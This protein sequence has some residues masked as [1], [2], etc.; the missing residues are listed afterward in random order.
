MKKYIP[1]KGDRVREADRGGIVGHVDQVRHTSRGLEAKVWPDGAMGG[2]WIKA[3][4]LT[5]EGH[6]E[7]PPRGLALRILAGGA[8]GT[9]GF[10]RYPEGIFTTVIVREGA[11]P[12]TIRRLA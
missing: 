3:S 5:R 8:N 9:R 4:T 10:A 12:P 2:Y 11:R 6:D 7:R 1:M